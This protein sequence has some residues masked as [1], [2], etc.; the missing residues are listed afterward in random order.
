MK[1]IKASGNC[2]LHAT[3]STIAH[4]LCQDRSREQML[5][6][7]L[8]R[9]TPCNPQT[10]FAFHSLHL[11]TWNKQWQRC[12]AHADEDYLGDAVAGRTHVRGE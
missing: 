11:L 6:Q 1:S 8:N 2:P 5:E 3:K 4:V 12:D 7:R 10:N 9:Y